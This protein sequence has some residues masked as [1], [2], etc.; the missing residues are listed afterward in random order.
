MSPAPRRL[1]RRYPYRSVE[2]VEDVIAQQDRVVAELA[3]M[4]E[5]AQDPRTKRYLREQERQARTVLQWLTK[6]RDEMRKGPP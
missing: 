6:L 4:R 3:E 2:E 5:A 1:G